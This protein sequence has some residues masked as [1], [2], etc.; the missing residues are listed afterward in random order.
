MSDTDPSIENFARLIGPP[1][2][3]P[4]EDAALST[5]LCGLRSENGLSPRMSWTRQML[6]MSLTRSGRR[7]R[8]KKFQVR[9]M[10]GLARERVSSSST[11]RF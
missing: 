2:L 8:Y 7:N 11:C 1:A 10:E 9:I 5:R 4:G 6:V 3:L